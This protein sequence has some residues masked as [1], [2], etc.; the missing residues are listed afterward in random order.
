MLEELADMKRKNE[1][2]SVELRNWK[3][4]CETAWHLTYDI[5]KVV[6]AP[7]AVL[8]P[9]SLINHSDSEKPPSNKQRTYAEVAKIP[10]GA[11]A[12]VQKLQQSPHPVSSSKPTIIID[13]F[14][15]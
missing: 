2:P 12:H 7:Q 1:K 10:A 15:G 3:L 6:G 5:S 14:G 9:R 4:F 13:A 8:R 11:Q